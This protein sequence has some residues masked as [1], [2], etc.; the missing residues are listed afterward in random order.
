MNNKIYCPSCDRLLETNQ[1]TRAT[2]EPIY[3]CKDCGLKHII[4]SH[5]IYQEGYTIQTQR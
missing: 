1:L 3:I 4:R 2:K 5:K